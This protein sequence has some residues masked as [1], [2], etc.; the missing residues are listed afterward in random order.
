MLRNILTLALLAASAAASP[1]ERRAVCVLAEGENGY[2]IDPFTRPPCVCACL[3]AAC[4][5][6]TGSDEDYLRCVKT[7][8]PSSENPWS[9]ELIASFGACTGSTRCIG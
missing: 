8:W 2:T 3:K 4:E 6:V 1:V 5:N 9:Y 7:P